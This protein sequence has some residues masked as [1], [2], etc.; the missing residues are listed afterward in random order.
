[1][2]TQYRLIPVSAEGKFINDAQA[3]GMLDSEHERQ[4]KPKPGCR[5][6]ILVD[7]AAGNEDFNPESLLSG[8][9]DTATDST[10]IWVYEVSPVLASNGLFPNLRLVNLKWIT[11]APLPESEKEIDSMIS[12]WGAA[13]VTIDAVGVGRQIAEAMETKYGPSIITKYMA[14]QNSVA[15][16]CYDLLA[17][18]NFQSVKMFRDDGSPEWKEFER[19]LGWTKYASS[20]GKMKLIKPDAKKH[21]DMVKALTYIHQNAPV[22]GFAEIYNVESE[23]EE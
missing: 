9:E 16:D 4:L 5:Y 17:R 7:I 20:L 23:Y 6:E 19:Q 8:E 2:K 3:R 14:D 15:A 22:A 11:G 1:M 12:Y 21:I 18:L 13:R 10:I